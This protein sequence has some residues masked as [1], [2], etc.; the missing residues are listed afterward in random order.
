VYQD[1]DREQPFVRIEDMASHS[2]RS[3]RKV[4]PNGPYYLGG[5]AVGGIV[6]FE[7][8]QQL[9]RQGQKVALLTLCECWTSRARSM[10]SKSK[11]QRLWQKA[12]YH[13]HRTRRIGTKQE[14]I[15]LLGSLKEKSRGLAGHR[16]SVSLTPGEKEARVAIVEARTRYVPQVYSGRIILIRCS[17][18]PSWR[19]HDPLDGWGNFATE[20]IEMYEVQG[21][22]ATI[23]R[24]PNVGILARTLNDVLHKAQAELENGRTAL[25]DPSVSL[26]D[27]RSFEGPKVNRTEGKNHRHDRQSILESPGG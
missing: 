25:V 13:F 2:I 27:S 10:G 24:E 15:E 12:S 14:L 20:G 9:R 26:F 21:G 17:T 8:A 22:H 6:A 16:K 18:R 19:D 1:L 7:M 11:A 3:V 4:Q 5:H 23:Y